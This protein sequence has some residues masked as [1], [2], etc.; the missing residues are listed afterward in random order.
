MESQFVCFARE[1]IIM[2][3]LEQAKSAIKN[4][5]EFSLNLREFGYVIDY[6]YV[7]K[8]TFVGST[9]EE[10]TIL[11]NLRGT[12]FNKAGKIIRL[13]YHKFHNLN[14]NPEYSEA[15]IAEKT[16]GKPYDI[17]QKLDGSMVAPIP[18]PDGGWKFGTR[19]GVTEVAAKAQAFYDSMEPNKKSYYRSYIQFCLQENYTPIFEYCAR[20]QRIVIDYPEPMLVLTGCRNNATGEYCILHKSVGSEFPGYYAITQVADRLNNSSSLSEVAAYVKTLQNDEGIV[21]KYA[22]GVFVKIKADEYVLKHRALDG[23]RFEKDVAALVLQD[24]LDDV[25]PIVTVDLRDRL[26]AYRDSLLAN[27]KDQEF[28]LSV[29]WASM[30]EFLQDR[31]RFAAEAVR[32]GRFRPFLFKL[33][34]GKSVDLREFALSK[35]SSNGAVE[36]NRWLFGKPYL[37]F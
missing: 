8:D 35:T 37:E 21:M 17:E 22:N 11:Q 33:L 18:M 34:D 19:A 36:E 26:T 28:Q 29:A 9:P 7:Q 27:I 14:E 1:E 10:T 5:P 4:K 13:C 2:F 23:L 3:T 25:L 31:A 15:A 6:N 12:C 24:Q 20:D 16:A 30:G 32:F